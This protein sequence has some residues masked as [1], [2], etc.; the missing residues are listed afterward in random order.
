MGAV[1]IQQM[2]DRVAALMEDRLKV[3]GRTLGQKLRRGGFHLPHK[4]RRQALVLARSADMA[5]NPKLLLQ[6]DE[7]RVAQAYDIC[8][9]HLNGVNVWNRRKG[10]MINL[11]ASVA[12]S[13]LVVGVL[14]VALLV[15]RGYL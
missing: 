3:Q 6:I 10:V 14:L 2:A 11:G 8:I 4:V 9:R 5:R 1:A 13:L 15:W 7:G 12:G